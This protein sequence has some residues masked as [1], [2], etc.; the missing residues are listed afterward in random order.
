MENVTIGQIVAV[1]GIIST[2][3]GFFVAIY[4]FIKKV[5]LDKI[6]KNTADIK[7]LQGKVDMIENEI[8]DGKEEIIA[9]DS[10]HPSQMK[11]ADINTLKYKNSKIKIDSKNAT[12]TNANIYNMSKTEKI[13]KISFDNETIMLGSLQKGEYVLEIIAKYSQGNAYYGI[14]IVVE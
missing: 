10:L 13:K 11:Y 4:K 9:A 5:V 2:I 7:I 8:K 3:A 6:E 1:I 14:K 12:I